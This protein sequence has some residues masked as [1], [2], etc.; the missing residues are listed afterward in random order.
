MPKPQVIEEDKVYRK[1]DAS[2]K[3]AESLGIDYDQFKFYTVNR[4]LEKVS[5]E[6]RKMTFREALMAGAEGA[7]AKLLSV[8]WAAATPRLIGR[9]IAQV[10]TGNTPSIRVPKAAK[11]KAYR[12]GQAGGAP[13]T[14]EKYTYVEITARLWECAPVV[15]RTLVEDAMWDVIERQYAEASRAIAEAESGEVCTEITAAGDANQATGDGSGAFNLPDLTA[16]IAKLEGADYNATD[17]IMHPN[18]FWEGL[19]RDSSII[20][21]SAFGAGQ[22]PAYTGQ[23]AQIFGLRTWVTSQMTPKKPCVIDREKAAVLYVRR[24]ITV[25]DYEDPMKD[26]VGAVVTS[27]FRCKIVDEKAVVGLTTI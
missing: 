17:I 19:M 13:E 21:A 8:V 1:G 3:F 22:A 15:S 4:R 2:L 24:D 23:L 18:D 26:L 27:R 10:M 6:F 20:D 25:E 12:V 14:A 9:E 7:T 16:M 5:E 11:A